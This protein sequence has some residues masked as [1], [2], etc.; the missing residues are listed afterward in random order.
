MKQNITL[1]IDRTLL[2]RARAVAAQ[3]GTSISGLL[4]TELQR[5]VQN[6]EEYQRARVRALA[7]LASPP[8]RLGGQGIGNREALHDRQ[9]LR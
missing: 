1:A 3:R 7:M 5:L 6:E 9:G 4:A 8:F 2:K